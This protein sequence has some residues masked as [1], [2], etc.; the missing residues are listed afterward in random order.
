MTPRRLSIVA[1]LTLGAW[2]VP[3][4]VVAQR[5][6]NVIGT[7]A[8]S[9]PASAACPSDEP[10]DPP[11]TAVVLSFK[12]SGRAAVSVLVRRT[13]KLRLAAGRYAISARSP[14]AP[15]RAA[16]GSPVAPAGAVLRPSTVWVPRRGAVHLHLTLG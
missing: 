14:A 9:A 1:L 8:R 6:P 7:L 10:C 2:L 15:R 11:A 13:F 5:P 12:R 16:A 3:G 4:A